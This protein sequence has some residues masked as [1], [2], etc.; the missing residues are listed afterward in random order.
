L[1]CR[2]I[3]CT[4]QYAPVCGSDGK[5]YG[6]ICFLNAADCES[7]EDIT[8]VHPGPCHVVCPQIECVTPCP[9]GYIGPVNGC[10]TCQCK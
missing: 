4:L 3:F 6:N 9:F 7:E 1:K 2:K 5:T 8:V 10:P